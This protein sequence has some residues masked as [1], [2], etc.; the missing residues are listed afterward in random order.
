[1]FQARNDMPMLL[2]YRWLFHLRSNIS[3]N[4]KQSWRTYL[5]CFNH[6]TGGFEH[7]VDVYHYL[8][9]GGIAKDSSA[10]C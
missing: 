10:P 3:F 4:L 7:V 1:V 6:W 9:S 5:S 2:R 8:F